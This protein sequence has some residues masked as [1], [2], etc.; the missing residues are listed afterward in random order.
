MSVWRPPTVLIVVTAV[1][2]AAVL[3]VTVGVLRT[4]HH[5]AV[6]DGAT[7]RLVDPASFGLN[8][9]HS[10]A[11]VPYGAVR[12]WDTRTTWAHLEPARGV[13]EWAAVC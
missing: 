10:A 5:P 1:V 13:F 3:A 9:V 6:P 8:I 4:P 12:L 2:T 11:T 7:A